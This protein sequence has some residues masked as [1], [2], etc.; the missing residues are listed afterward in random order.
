MTWY[1]GDMD[2]GIVLV[3]PTRQECVR[4][5]LDDALATRVIERHTYGPG[6]YE[7]TVAGDDPQDCTSYFVARLDRADVD[8]FDPDQPP[9]YG[10]PAH[11]HERTREDDR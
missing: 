11:P 10:D 8:G 4:W 6:R 7:Y 5:A 2:D 3:R 9:L 1:I